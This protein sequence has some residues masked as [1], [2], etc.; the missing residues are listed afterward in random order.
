MEALAKV[1]RENAAE[2]AE[3]EMI[4]QIWAENEVNDLYWEN[5]AKEFRDEELLR[6]E[7]SLD[8]VYSFDTILDF[9]DNEL[10]VHQVSVELP[11]NE[12]PENYT[13]E[14]SQAEYP[15]P[16]LLGRSERISM[17]KAKKFKFDANG[18]RSTA[19][20]AFDVSENEK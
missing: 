16:N 20:K 1:E 15:D 13:T 5:M 10:N 17:M 2:E 19:D 9:Q 14:E 11:A 4:R 7:D 3:Q 8:N 18:T 6:P 12:A